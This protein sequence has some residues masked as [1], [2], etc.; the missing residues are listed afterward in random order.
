MSLT[1]RRQTTTP[2]PAGVHIGICYAIYDLG[3]QHI[4]AF[5][6]HVHQIIICWEL[7]A[8]RIEIEK[9]GETKEIARMISAKYTLSLDRRANLLKHLECWRG[10]EFTKAELD[11]FDLKKVVGVPCQLQVAHNDKGYAKIQ[12]I[13]SMPSG[14]TAPL[15]EREQQWFSFEET[16]IIPDATPNWIKKEIMKSSEW[17]SG[18]TE[19]PPEQPESDQPADPND[20]NLPF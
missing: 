16:M 12:S 9:D 2:V 6:K 19:Q 15:L 17:N 1:A 8:V 20:D 18:S 5:G 14:Q 3:T 10:V 13:M 11:G 7:P 4:E